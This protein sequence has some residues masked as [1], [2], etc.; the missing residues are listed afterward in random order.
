MARSLFVDLLAAGPGLIPVWEGLDLAGLIDSWLP[1]WSAVRSRPQRNAVHRHTVD[2]HLIETVVQATGLMRDVERP[3]L[4]LLAALLHD[5]GKIAGA[6]DHSVVGAPLAATAVR[7]MG[8]DDA[9]VEVVELLTR[10]HLT[11]ID[12]ATRR[13]PSRPGHHLGGDR[14]GCRPSRRPGAASRPD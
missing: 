6:H 1:E 11:L 7:R 8:L 4:L 9:E 3:D 10:E 13:D 12:L 2:R 14:C 5:I